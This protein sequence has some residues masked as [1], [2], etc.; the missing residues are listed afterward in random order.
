MKTTNKFR[1]FKRDDTGREMSP[2]ALGYKERFYYFRFTHRGKAYPR[3]LETNDAAEAQ[4]RA[5]A[6][7]AEIVA[8]VSA[9][10]FARLDA[11]K[12]RQSRCATV[13][14]LLAAYRRGP[15]EAAAKTRQCNINAFLQIAAG[16]ATVREL[17]PALV[18][19]YFDTITAR[20]LA[21]PDQTVAASMKRTANSVWAAA[22][23]LFTPK[24]LADYQDRGLLISFSEIE[25]FL[26]AGKERRFDKKKLKIIYRPP[27]DEIITR[28][29]AAW[30]SLLNRDMFLVIGHALAFGLRKG[31]MI[32]ARWNWHQQ[33]QGYPVLDGEANVKNG[34][35]LVQVRA[36]DPWFSHLQTIAR[37]R[38]WWNESG[39]S[40]DLIIKG[41]P[42]YQRE[43]IYNAVSAW[44]RDL[45]WQTQKTNHALRA[46]A[47]SQV[48]MKYGIWEASAWLRHSSVEVTQSHYMYFLKTFPVADKELISARWAETPK[49]TS[50][51]ADVTLDATS[52][53]R[54][55]PLDSATVL[56]WTLETRN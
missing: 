28:T 48:A 46:Y 43:D 32:Q 17:T 1:L 53:F 33:R 11:A 2:G 8:A 54:K 10:A 41:T 27:A 6:R 42:T 47:G 22:A 29:L 23:S 44:L 25:S 12:L 45:G 5:K 7:Y 4:R 13:Q 18:R 51:A 50:V 49:V 24:C 19:K 34:S 21:E 55:A 31:E 30:Q 16:A 36:L 56:P 35:G 20:A 14:E 39:N 3:C 37:A 15:S 52:D 26:R 9:G 40:D 38:G